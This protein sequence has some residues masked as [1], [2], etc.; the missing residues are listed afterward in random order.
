MG[1]GLGMLRGVRF[2]QGWIAVDLPRTFDAWE[3]R[4]VDY[5]LVVGPD[6]DASPIRAFEVTPRT[7]TLACGAPRECEKEVEETFRLMLSR[8]PLL[9]DSLRL[10]SQRYEKLDAPGLQSR[11]RG[12]L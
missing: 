6:G 11:S 8:D 2:L 9:M 7:L 12:S 5:F 4:L 3:K 1:Y 10:G